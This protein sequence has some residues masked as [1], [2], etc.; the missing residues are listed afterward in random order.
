MRQVL[1][2]VRALLQGRTHVCAP[3][4][5]KRPSVLSG[6]TERTNSVTTG[7]EGRARLQD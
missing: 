5:P 6:Q 7:M 2:K 4:G 1:S 3:G